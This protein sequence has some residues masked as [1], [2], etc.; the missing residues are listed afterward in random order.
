MIEDAHEFLQSVEH[1]SSE[2]I[3]DAVGLVRGRCRCLLHFIKVEF[4]E[5]LSHYSVEQR[6]YISDMMRRLK[7]KCVCI[8][9]H[10]STVVLHSKNHM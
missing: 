2:E 7:E 3:R 5:N 8:C 9:N 10:F 1:C 4:K 6:K